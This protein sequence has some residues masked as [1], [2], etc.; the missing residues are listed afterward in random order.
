MKKG[1]GI[2][3]AGVVTNRKRV[4]YQTKLTEDIEY[5]S[6][7]IFRRFQAFAG[8]GEKGRDG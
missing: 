6:G 8:G 2:E 1:R 4:G 7:G 3:S 5:M